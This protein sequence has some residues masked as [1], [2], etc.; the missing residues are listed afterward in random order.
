MRYSDL[1]NSARVAEPLELI[2]TTGDLENDRVAFEVL[3]R[4]GNEI[5][6]LALDE[7]SQES[8]ALFFSGDGNYTMS[9]DSLRKIVAALEKIA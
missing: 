9:L 8:R 5:I 6:C 4:D 3:D 2:M 1:L 7:V